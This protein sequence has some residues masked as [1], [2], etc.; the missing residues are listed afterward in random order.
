MGQRPHGGYGPRQDPSSP[1]S[2]VISIFMN[3]ALEQQVPV[4]YG[5]GKQ[6]RDFIFVNDVVKA[7]LLA[8]KSGNVSKGI[9][10][11][12]TGATT[13]I[14]SLWDL[15]SSMAEIDLEPQLEAP[16]AGDIFG[17]QADSTR[18]KQLIE[19]EPGWT[20]EEGLGVTY[21]WYR[22]G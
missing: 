3:K 22:Q 10:N 12:G 18:A 11:I 20:F 2:G 6:Y 8:A 4:I 16:R 19:F 21:A 1:Y 15:I 5:D 13:T 14:K 17:S 9:L 7:N